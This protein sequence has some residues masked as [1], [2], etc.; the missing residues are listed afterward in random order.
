[1]GNLFRRLL[2]DAELTIQRE[3]KLLESR[4]LCH[5]NQLGVP[6]GKVL[7]ERAET[8]KL[9]SKLRKRLIG[10]K[11]LFNEVS[12]LGALVIN[13]I[14]FWPTGEHPAAM[15]HGEHGI[16]STF[17]SPLIISTTTFLLTFY[18]FR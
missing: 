5:W 2:I 11:V 3:G 17:S 16:A 1:M 15:Q 13:A 14:S 8:Q 4:T 18:F 6:R 12:K 9:S 10:P 7:K